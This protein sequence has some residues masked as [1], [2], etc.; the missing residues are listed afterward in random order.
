LVVELVALGLLIFGYAVK[1]MKNYRRHGIIM[2]TAVILHLVTIFSWMIWSF[3]SFFSGTAVD[4]TN[5]IILIAL[6]HAPLGVI[7]AVFGIYLVTAW[8]LQLDIQGC[9]KRKRIMLTT[10]TIWSTAISL[11]II[12]YL[13]VI[14]SA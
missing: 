4:F 14:L 2:T 1:R 5:P 13:A 11:G 7:A 12:L 6:I 3:I 10:I 8:H 9:F